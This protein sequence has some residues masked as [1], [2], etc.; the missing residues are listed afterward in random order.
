MQL[1][2]DAGFGVPISWPGVNFTPPNTGN[3]VEV[4]LFENEPTNYGIANDD[5]ESPRGILQVTA[6]GRPGRGLVALNTLAEQI[7][8]AFPKGARIE[9]Q[10]RVTRQPWRLGDITEDDRV[11]IPVSISYSS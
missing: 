10:I 9:G 6:C 8:A 7:Q 1:V 11:K 5:E 4:T 3:W 2:S